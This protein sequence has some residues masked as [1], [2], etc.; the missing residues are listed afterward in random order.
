MQQLTRILQGLVVVSE[1][2]YLHA[3]QTVGFFDT[4]VEVAHEE[5]GEVKP[6]QLKQ[7]LISVHRIGTIYPHENEAGISFGGK[8]LRLDAIRR[9]CYR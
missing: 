4:Y 3:L 1:S 5:V 6:C 7:Q 9:T 8:S 2:L